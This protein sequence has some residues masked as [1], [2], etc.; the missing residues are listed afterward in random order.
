MGRI[1]IPKNRGEKRVRRHLRVRKQVTGTAERPRLV[2][3]PF[4]EAHHRPARGRRRGA[5]AR[6]GRRR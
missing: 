5:H 3:Y 4:A 2:V 6:D 1:G